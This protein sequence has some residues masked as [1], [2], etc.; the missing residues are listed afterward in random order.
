[1]TDKEAIRKEIKSLEAKYKATRSEVE[2]A[3]ITSKIRKLNKELSVSPSTN[4]SSMV[5]RDAPVIADRKTSPKS[6]SGR[7]IIRPDES[8]VFSIS[9]Y[10]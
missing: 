3:D 9:A 2:K 5:I 4:P 10:L 6:R 8:G 1:M 7:S